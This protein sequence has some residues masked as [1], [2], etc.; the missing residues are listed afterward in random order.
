MRTRELFA[1]LVVVLAAACGDDGGPAAPD[2]AP[3]PDARPSLDPALFDC[4][5]VAGGLPDRASSV[6]IA[7]ALDPACLTIQVSG[8]RG[9]GGNDLGALAPEDSLTE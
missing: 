6:P 5:S 8:H 3:A 4:T 1:A 2:A 7:C 9:V